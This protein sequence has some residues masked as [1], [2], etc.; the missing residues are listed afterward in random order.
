MT[1]F[2]YRILRRVRRYFLP[3]EIPQ[4]SLPVLPEGYRDLEPPSGTTN[5]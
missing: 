4:K 3:L 1:P 5:G 2:I